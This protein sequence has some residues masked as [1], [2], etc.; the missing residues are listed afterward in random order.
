MKVTQPDLRFSIEQIIRCEIF[1]RVTD[2]SI[3]YLISF[4]LRKFVDSTPDERIEFLT[5][6]PYFVTPIDLN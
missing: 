1:H 6:S 5:L 4:F 2:L 3:I